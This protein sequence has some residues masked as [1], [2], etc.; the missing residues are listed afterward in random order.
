MLIFCFF[1]IVM[2]VHLILRSSPSDNSLRSHYGSCASKLTSRTYYSSSPSVTV[3]TVSKICQYVGSVSSILCSLCSRLIENTDVNAVLYG[4]EQD[5][6]VEE[7]YL[8]NVI[9]T[10]KSE[11]VDLMLA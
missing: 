2:W 1:L 8:I 3:A 11:L 7:E 5:L 9:I 10:R 6:G 4:I